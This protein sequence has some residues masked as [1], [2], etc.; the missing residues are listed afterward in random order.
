MERV[1]HANLQ[2]VGVK[3]V[4]FVRHVVVGNG[5][6]DQQT[7]IERRKSLRLYGR[8]NKLA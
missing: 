4:H 6:E 7:V 1:R 2:I 3:S 8:K 5:T